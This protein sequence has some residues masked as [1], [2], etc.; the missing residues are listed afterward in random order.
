MATCPACA[1]LTA[2][3]Q[4]FCPSCGAAI[5]LDTLPTGTAP[6]PRPPSERAPSPP[7]RTPSA[8]PRTPPAS[9][10]RGTST[11]TTGVTPLPP[12]RFVPGALLF[13]DRYRIVALLG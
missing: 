12:P 3:G 8:G 6:R 13:G 4:R 7:P 9:S 11:T 2:E 10:S 1:H 5:G